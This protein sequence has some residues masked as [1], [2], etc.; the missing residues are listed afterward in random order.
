MPSNPPINDCATLMTSFSLTP[1]L[2]LGTNFF[3]SLLPD[4][5][6]Q[7]VVIDEYPGETDWTMGSSLPSIEEYHFQVICRDVEQNY[8][9]N[10]IYIQ[11]IYRSIIQVANQTVGGTNQLWWEPIHTPSFSHRDEKKRIHHIF[12]FYAMRQPI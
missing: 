6:D 1:A 8:N 11:S 10:Q 9:T 12:S 2:V 3:M 5:P 7:C 4:A